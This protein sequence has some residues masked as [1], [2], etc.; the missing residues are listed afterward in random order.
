[1]FKGKQD[2]LAAYDAGG[3]GSGK[4]SPLSDGLQG[5]WSLWQACGGLPRLHPL[6]VELLSVMHNKYHRG[7]PCST[8]S[9]TCTPAPLCI[10]QGRLGVMAEE[11]PP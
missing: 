8:R 4:A 6:P 11:I 7:Q 10:T 3:G 5:T 1:M 2:T 9:L